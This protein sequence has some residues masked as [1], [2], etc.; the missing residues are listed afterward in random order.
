MSKWNF[1]PLVEV[2]SAKFSDCHISIFDKLS[3]DNQR[4]RK[5]MD[6][7]PIKKIAK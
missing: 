4:E 3:V 5:F 7:L 2:D 1:L 6:S